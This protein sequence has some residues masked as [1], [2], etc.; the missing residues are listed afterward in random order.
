MK[1]ICVE[2]LLMQCRNLVLMNFL[3]V[4]ALQTT[5]LS[6]I[7]SVDSLFTCLLCFFVFV[8]N[9]GSFLDESMQFLRACKYSIVDIVGQCEILW[10]HVYMDNI[11]G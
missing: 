2:L 6:V 1:A 5:Y 10:I 3:L 7:Q 9:Y 11:R 8:L 4:Y